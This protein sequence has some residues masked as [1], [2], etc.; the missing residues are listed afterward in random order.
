MI[1]L[2]KRL[3]VASID[4]LGRC[5]FCVRSAALSAAGAW[6]V[7]IALLILAPASIAVIVAAM[8]AIALSTLWALH[9]SAYAAR[10]V[11]VRRERGA[12]RA[13]VRSK[14]PTRREA[15]RTFAGAFFGLA[16]TSLFIGSAGRAIAADEGCTD[17]TPSSC[18]TEY[19]CSAP[20]V[21]HCQGYTGTSEPWR[22]MVNFCTRANSDEDVADLRSNCDVLT[23]C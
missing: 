18:G 17:E 8:G 2:F 19:C 11:R 5:I 7:T 1:G 3:H 23:A 4:D 10:V 21:W 6:G 14:A 15:M 9:L 20:A 22:T 16:L 12:L 13:D